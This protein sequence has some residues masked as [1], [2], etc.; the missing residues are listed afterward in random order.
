MTHRVVRGLVWARACPRPVCIPKS[1]PKGAKA[2]GLRYERSLAQALPEA[3][4]GPWFQFCDAAGLGYCQPDLVLV[5]PDWVLVLEAKLSWTAEGHSQIRQLYAPVLEKV[6]SRRVVGVVVTKLLRPE[7]P[8][9]LVCGNL[10]R[11]IVVAADTGS[12]VLH[13]L[14]KCPLRALSRPVAG[15][16]VAGVAPPI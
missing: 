7:T 6:Y 2:Q 9:S 12:A 15:G 4:H 14:G 16:H 5:R 1:R 13:W 8:R 11:A 3:T 10:E